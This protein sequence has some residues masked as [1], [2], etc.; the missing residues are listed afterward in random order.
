MSYSNLSGKKNERI[1][2]V[3]ILAILLA[4]IFFA[5]SYLSQI[6]T[7]NNHYKKPELYW[8]ITTG[9]IGFFYR[10][11]FVDITGDAVP[12]LIIGNSVD[13]ITI[14]NITT[15]NILNV[16]RV[17]NSTYL[18]ILDYGYYVS[19]ITNNLEIIIFCHL[20]N[21]SYV[22][23]IIDAVTGAFL[24]TYS[25]EPNTDI[26]ENLILFS[27]AIY[28]DN[29]HENLIILGWYMNRSTPLSFVYAI[30]LESKEREW[31]IDIPGWI[32]VSTL[33]NATY[34]ANY[35]KSTGGI[36]NSN[37]KWLVLWAYMEYQNGTTTNDA[38]VLSC[39]NFTV[40]NKY[41]CVPLSKGIRRVCFCESIRRQ[42]MGFQ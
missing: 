5:W 11:K 2:V 12:E 4:N 23:Y 26:P 39:I 14:Y 34:V 38:Y 20:K 37:E 17:E 3:I 22:I 16:I 27:K 35:A 15:R 36:S 24:W 28:Y 8:K 25:L 6:N 21:E 1:I 7:G 33:I 40:E 10:P 19:N 29:K 42:E 13:T 9:D 41:L 31:A 30:N 32:S 18:K